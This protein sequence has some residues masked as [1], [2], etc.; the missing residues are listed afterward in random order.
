MQPA[1]RHVD[2]VGAEIIKPATDQVVAH[3]LLR[4][5]QPKRKGQAFGTARP[6]PAPERVGYFS[7]VE[8]LLK[9]VLS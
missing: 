7:E 2:I 3:R 4:F 8:M 1:D 6:Q 9:L 5:L